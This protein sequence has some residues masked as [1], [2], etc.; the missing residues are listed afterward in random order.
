ML[1]YEQNLIP[2]AIFIPRP[3]KPRVVYMTQ[4]SLSLCLYLCMVAL[5]V[6]V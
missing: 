2:Y 1:H 6:N 5:T 4:V 3:I